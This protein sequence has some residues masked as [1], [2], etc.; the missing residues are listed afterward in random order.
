MSANSLGPRKL[1]AIA[2]LTGMDVVRAS[3]WSHVD[4]GRMAHIRTRDGRCWW[5]DRQTGDW[6]PHEHCS[7]DSVSRDRA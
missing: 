1:A 3:V 7:P 6:S 2:R 4:S 5:L